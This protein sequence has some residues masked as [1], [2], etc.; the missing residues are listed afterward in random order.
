MGLGSM[1]GGR[2]GMFGTALLAAAFY[3]FFMRGRGGNSAS[4]SWGSYY[5]FWIVAPRFSRRS[6]RTRS[7]SSSS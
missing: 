4:S 1:L 2:S 5:L 6:R 7:F 3:F